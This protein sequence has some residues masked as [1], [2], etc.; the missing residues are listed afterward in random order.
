MN[1]ANGNAVSLLGLLGLLGQGHELQGEVSLPEARRAVIR[2]RAL[3]DR[4]AGGFTRQPVEVERSGHAKVIVA[5]IDDN[6]LWR[7]FGDFD[8]FVTFVGEMGAVSIYWA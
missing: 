7:R 5:G 8:R 1:V 2:A 6:Y 3:F 4:Q